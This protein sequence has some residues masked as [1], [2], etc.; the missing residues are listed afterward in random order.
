M[1]LIGIGIDGLNGTVLIVMNFGKLHTSLA[2]DS[3]GPG[4][5]MVE[6]IPLAFDLYDGV[7]GCPSDNGL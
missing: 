1:E 3:A 6:Q 5:I 4:G 2:A 7:M